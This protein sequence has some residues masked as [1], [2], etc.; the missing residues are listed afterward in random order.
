MNKRSFSLIARDT[1]WRD[2]STFSFASLNANDRDRPRIYS[3]NGVGGF[4]QTITVQEGEVIDYVTKQSIRKADL[5]LNVAFAGTSPLE[6][7]RSFREW[8]A[9]YLDANSYR[10]ALRIADMTIDGGSIGEARYVDVLIKK[11]LPQEISGGVSKATLTLQPISLPYAK[12]ENRIVMNG[13][14]TAKSYPYGYPYS[15][16]VGSYGGSNL[17]RNNFIKRV[18]VILVLHGPIVAPEVSL[19]KDGSL[20][21]YATVSLPNVT[22]AAGATVRVDAVNERVTHIAANGTTTDYYNQTDKSKDSFLYADPGDSTI[23]VNL[24]PNEPAAMLEFQMV[25]YTI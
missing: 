21:A 24:D 2:L 13:S 5:V 20:T 6:G 1:L 12:T 15:Y 17:I 14:N 8:C 23:S 9:T 3:P 11:L 22:I 10:I 4:E 16:G 7:I 19:F 18:P 25:A